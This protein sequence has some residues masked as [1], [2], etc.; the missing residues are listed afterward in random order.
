MCLTEY[1]KVYSPFIEAYL[2]ASCKHYKREQKKKNPD[3]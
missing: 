1:E 2:S 3:Q